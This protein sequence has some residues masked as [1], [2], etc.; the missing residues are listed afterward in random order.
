VSNRRTIVDGRYELGE[1]LGNGRCGDV[2]RVWDRTDRQTVAL[3]WARADPADSTVLTE[4]NARVARERDLLCSLRSP[5][6]IGVLGS[7]RERGREF[8][9]ME[10]ATG[11]TLG[12]R[13]RA[14]LRGDP[15][16]TASIARAL[17]DGLDEIHALGF[18]HRDI[19]PG[20]LLISSALEDPDRLLDT[21]QEQVLIADL[22]IAVR[23]GDG[24]NGRDSRRGT[25]LYRA[26]EQSAKASA[27]S[28]TADVHGATAVIV[29]TLT[30]LLPP[31]PDQL[32]ELLS[33]LKPRWQAFVSTGM[34]RSPGLRFPTMTE[35]KSVLSEAIN[36]DL[37]EAGFDEIPT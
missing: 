24:H 28:L 9:V 10:L 18:V 3:K 34:H 11:G 1:K 17:A 26:P 5:H 8:M 19:E 22:G 7:G 37:Q 31:P 36:H 25:R 4:N 16:S 23:P 35:W 15:W 27:V 32:D 14:G 30:G 29:T 12:A 21:E 13:L 2:Y 6:V 33:H 20:N